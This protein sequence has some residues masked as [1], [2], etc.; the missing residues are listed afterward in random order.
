MDFLLHFSKDGRFWII[1]TE[2]RGVGTYGN[3]AKDL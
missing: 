1:P 3:R 2:T